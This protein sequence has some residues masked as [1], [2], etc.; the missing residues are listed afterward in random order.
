[1]RAWANQRNEGWVRS[2]WLGVFFHNEPFTS[3]VQ[4]YDSL[5]AL[6]PGKRFEYTGRSKGTLSGSTRHAQPACLPP[7]CRFSDRK[8]AST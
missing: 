7:P 2:T 4:V 6:D 5:K 8:R 3:G 1:M